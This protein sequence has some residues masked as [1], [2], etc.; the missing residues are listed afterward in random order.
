MS[1]SVF[2]I[3]A[4]E[5]IP[6]D[7]SIIDLVLWSINKGRRDF[8]GTSSFINK[9]PVFYI[10]KS[11]S[12]NINCKWG[13]YIQYVKDISEDEDFEVDK[14]IIKDLFTDTTIAIYHER[15]GY[16]NREQWN[17]YVD[18]NFFIIGA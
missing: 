3:G 9:M 13:D 2:I 15:V 8:L 17:E 12:Y 10:C 18:Q 11:A 14:Q 7:L 16:L 4:G 5:K 1:S 6:T